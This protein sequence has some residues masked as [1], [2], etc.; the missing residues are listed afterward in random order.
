MTQWTSVQTINQLFIWSS[1]EHSLND[2]EQ[3]SIQ[4]LHIM[5]LE[6][7]I[8]LPTEWLCNI[9]S[10]YSPCILLWEQSEKLLQIKHDFSSIAGEESGRLINRCSLMKNY[11]SKSNK[12]HIEATER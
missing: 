4:F 12:L 1:F 10:G 7:F 3:E 2:I 8:V 9:L 11:K 6:L 5:L